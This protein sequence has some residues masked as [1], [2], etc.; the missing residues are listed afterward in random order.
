MLTGNKKQNSYQFPS[1]EEIVISKSDLHIQLQKYKS[2]IQ[3]S[4]SVF[5]FLAIFSLWVPVFTG[6]FTKVFNINPD[7]VK[8]GYFMLAV[9]LTLIILYSKISW[10]KDEMIS[11]DPEEMSSKILECCKKIKI[12]S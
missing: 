9:L 7:Q 11:A 5:D 4:F 10:R 3:S 1:S 12:N 6:G 8:G 2:T